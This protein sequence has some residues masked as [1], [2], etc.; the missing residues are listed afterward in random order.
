[1]GESVASR[2][3]NDHDGDDEVIRRRY[4]AILVFHMS[5]C[6]RCNAGSSGRNRITGH[7]GTAL[8]FLPVSSLFLFCSCRLAKSGDLESG[9]FAGRGSVA[10]S[11][12]GQW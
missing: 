1:M 3:D 7:G 2:R 9:Y 4:D 10:P 12:P 6:C 11:Q 8:S 5:A